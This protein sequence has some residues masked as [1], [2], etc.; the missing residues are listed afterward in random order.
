VGPALVLRRLGH[1]GPLM[2]QG[3]HPGTLNQCPL[4][5]VKGKS[6]GHASMSAND[7]KRI[8]GPVHSARAQGAGSN[9]RRKRHF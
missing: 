4:S 8:S 5:G 7:P 6:R 1:Y 2:A 9:W 3:G